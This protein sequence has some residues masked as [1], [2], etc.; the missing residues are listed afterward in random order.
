[1][2]GVEVAGAVLG[3]FPLLITALE[4]YRE[5][6]KLSKSSQ[7]ADGEYRRLQIGLQM[8]SVRVRNI[9][10][11]LLVDCAPE[12]AFEDPGSGAWTEQRY[13]D[14]VRKGLGNNYVLFIDIFTE[15]STSMRK[16]NANLEKWL[17]NS[18]RWRSLRATASL[19]GFQSTLLDIEKLADMLEEICR[20]RVS[21]NPMDKRDTATW[22]ALNGF[23]QNAVALRPILGNA[24]SAPQERI[25]LQFQ[26]STGDRL[27][28][29]SSQ[30]V[31]LLPNLGQEWD[32]LGSRPSQTWFD[33]RVDFSSSTAIDTNDSGDHSSLRKPRVR[34]GAPVEEQ[35]T[36]LF[37]DTGAA[38]SEML[39]VKGLPFSD[40]KAF[41]GHSERPNVGSQDPECIIEGPCIIPLK[42]LMARGAKTR[43]TRQARLALGATVAAMVVS[44]IDT[45]WLSN[46]PTNDKIFLVNR[47]GCV[48][49]VT[50]YLAFN[51]GETSSEQPCSDDDLRHRMVRLAGLLLELSL[52]EEVE[53]LKTS[54]ELTAESALIIL[55]LLPSVE[56]E[57]GLSYSRSIQKCIELG[58]QG[59]R[60]IV[61]TR[62]SLYKA[63]YLTV[64]DNYRLFLESGESP[65][66]GKVQREVDTAEEVL[67]NPAQSQ[68]SLERAVQY[69]SQS[70]E[71]ETIHDFRLLLE[72]ANNIWQA[73]QKSTDNYKLK[74]A[75]PIVHD[76]VLGI[77]EAILLVGTTRLGPPDE[78]E[79]LRLGKRILGC[80]RGLESSLQQ[81]STLTQKGPSDPLLTELQLVGGALAAFTSQIYGKFPMDQSSD[82]SSIL[83]DSMRS[84]PSIFGSEPIAESSATSIMEPD[85][86]G[87]GEVADKFVSLID[88]ETLLGPLFVAAA[89][90]GKISP[91]FWK[92]FDLLLFD[93]SQELVETVSG[94]N[95]M[96][97]HQTVAKMLTGKITYILE[98][99]QARYK[100][101]VVDSVTEDLVSWQAEETFQA[102]GEAVMQTWYRTFKVLFPDY[103]ESQTP[104]PSPFND[105]SLPT[106]GESKLPTVVFALVEEFL[107]SGRPFGNLRLGLRH[108]VEQTPM[109]IVEQEVFQGLH[110]PSENL[111]AVNIKVQWNLREY[112]KTELPGQ[113]TLD[114]ILTISGSASDAFAVPCSTYVQWLWPAAT[115]GP[116]G[117]IQSMLESG[118]Y[119]SLET[120]LSVNELSSEGSG[121]NWNIAVSLVGTKT[122]I[123][124]LAQ[125]LAWLACVF[126]KNTSD[127]LSLSEVEFMWTGQGEF[128]L[129]CGKDTAVSRTPD[130]CWHALL[131]PT[132]IAKDFPIP[133]RNGEV[134]LELPFQSLLRLSQ[135]SAELGWDD[136]VAL[137]APTRLLYPTSQRHFK[138]TQETQALCVQW[139]FI[140][141]GDP[142]AAASTMAQAESWLKI[143]D[144]TQLVVARTIVGYCKQV[145]INSGTENYNYEAMEES[146]LDEDQS[147]PGVMIKSITMGTSGAG[148]FGV[149][150]AMDIVYPRSM[151]V[152]PKIDTYDE[153][154]RITKHMSMI[155]YDAGE[156]RGWLLPTQS[157]IFHMVHCWIRKH[158]PSVQL[159]YVKAIW[160]D[161]DQVTKILR[162]N[163]KVKIRTL[164][165][166]D[167][168]WYLRDLVKQLW[169]DL[170]GCMLVRKQRRGEERPQ[171]TLPSPKLRAWEF[172]DFIES[173]MT[174]Y[175]RRES[176]SLSG[177]GWEALAD[178]DD[179]VILAARGFGEMIQPTESVK[180][181]R[182]WSRA[183]CNRMTLAACIRCM[184][185]MPRGKVGGLCMRLTRR[186]LWCPSAAD[187]LEDCSHISD[188]YCRKSLEKVITQTKAA[189]IAAES[190][191]PTGAVIFGV[192]KLQK[193][194]SAAEAVK[195]Q[196]V[197]DQG[198]GSG[199]SLKSWSKKLLGRGKK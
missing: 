142:L 152:S 82:V 186:V 3:A 36:T 2:S 139:H 174:I 60:S 103:L 91:A 193:P 43:L 131:G 127:Q 78:E 47:G 90:L 49:P 169:R 1:M 199:K 185:A 14:E 72:F 187:I 171:L 195:L 179:V 121:S 93:Y 66:D 44:L 87:P 122:T 79:L 53:Q 107:V 117:A 18:S 155:L 61:D 55:R 175:L 16:L 191:P 31:V 156:Q 13:E 29:L 143:E 98:K 112:M 133:T 184:Q 33:L 148:I 172:K 177:C 65:Y 51:T 7:R 73:T 163:Y 41:L 113:P 130:I 140:A 116:V 111:Y 4:H 154:L 8:V 99:L 75:S 128:E 118:P 145:A 123:V 109:E 96:T 81:S 30:C 100:D 89:G 24:E 136:G 23:R 115:I 108:L 192:K 67:G 165:D 164:L 101:K 34:F 28:A 105:S 70:V 35:S 149:Q 132:L 167:Q 189:Q 76:V 190:L 147:T 198:E 159:P 12:E 57:S 71:V 168:E 176:L 178:D 119:E 74:V 32:F 20:F 64:R 15:L 144:M 95:G 68:A 173:P 106:S 126:R 22:K 21:K 94:E 196:K 129:R 46:G 63:V 183:P 85:V 110:G 52:G 158:E 138:P 150:A 27:I 39:P 19:S 104:Q 80:F 59:R 58:T 137:Y 25:F 37:A 151:E 157:V 92:G 42:N 56:E 83:S 17:S 88:S 40:L 6:F 69:P 182:Q 162:E 10:E 54:S 170:Q 153:I 166:D 26:C 181:C 180:L 120:S 141:D 48:S 38:E 62:R 86:A 102:S 194:R 77:E 197:A 50:I 125:Q 160:E 188:T 84:E 135:V 134:G 114:R 5:G 97:S 45:P 9:L 161:D 11:V 124:H 146:Q